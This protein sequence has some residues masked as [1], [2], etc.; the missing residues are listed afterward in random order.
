MKK[1][2]TNDK[3]ILFSKIIV[4]VLRKIDEKIISRRR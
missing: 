4:P 3:D 1:I 2:K